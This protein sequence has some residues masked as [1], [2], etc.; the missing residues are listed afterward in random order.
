MKVTA[1]VVTYNRKEML[2]ECLEGLLKQTR[3]IDEIV[4]INNASSDGTDKFLKENGIL[5]HDII[6]YCK[7]ENNTGGAG[8]FYHGMKVAIERGADW[9]WTMDDDIEPEPD[10][11]KVQLSYTNMSECINATK[12]FTEN[13][14]TQYWEQF[15]DPFTARLFDLKNRSF[16]NGQN[17]CCVN[18]ACFEGML[19]SKNL[20][21]K[22]G[23]P[24]PGYFIYQ[25]DTV[26]GI[27]ASFFTNVVYV[28]TA[29]FR[30]KIYSYGNMNPFRV[31]YTLRNNFKVK[32]DITHMDQVGSGDKL[33][34][35]IFLLS[36]LRI[37]L[38]GLRFDFS[39]NMLKSIIKGW[40]HG[41]QGK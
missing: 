5:E 4:L 11:L 6:H 23:F 25:D 13:G 39:R 18:V 26:Y 33:S 24:E 37:T 10:A 34:N 15:Y 40:L 31:Y 2:L 20:I 17:W 35:F 14:E 22:I 32:R 29:I 19:V 41:L 3:P 9:L 1:V 16:E 28:K 27:K 30:K 12:I 21:E 36:Q 8:G 7:L 38:Q